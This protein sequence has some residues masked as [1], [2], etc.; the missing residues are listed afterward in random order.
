MGDIVIQCGT[1]PR[2]QLLGIFR[3]T[4][5]MG[6]N[7]PHPLG[8]RGAFDLGLEPLVCWDGRYAPRL[9]QIGFDRAPRQLQRITG[10]REQAVRRL[11]RHYLPELSNEL[12]GKPQPLPT[13]M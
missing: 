9:G 4:R 3:V 7:V 6:E 13:Q 1:R 11:I 8:W 12:E 10:D 5:E 2:N